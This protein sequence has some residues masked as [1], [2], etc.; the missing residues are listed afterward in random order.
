MLIFFAVGWPWFL[1]MM[2]EYGPLYYL[3]L[4]FGI[5][6]SAVTRATSAT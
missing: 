4:S 1:F 3:R 5:I 6:T 2:I